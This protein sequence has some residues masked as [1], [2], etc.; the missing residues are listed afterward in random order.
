MLYTLF[1]RWSWRDRHSDKSFLWLFRRPFCHSIELETQK[2]VECGMPRRTLEYCFE[3]IWKKIVDLNSY[4]LKWVWNVCILVQCMHPLSINS[5]LTEVYKR[6]SSRFLGIINHK[7]ITSLSQQ[8]SLIGQ[9]SFDIPRKA[10]QTIRR[11]HCS[12]WTASRV[13]ALL[14]LTTSWTLQL[15]FTIFVKKCLVQCVRTYLRILNISPVC[16]VSA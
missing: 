16:T 7:M 8:G 10:K 14:L 15:C 2:T 13:T 3:V 12:V 5:F 11:L 9:F 6:L 1:T 4:K